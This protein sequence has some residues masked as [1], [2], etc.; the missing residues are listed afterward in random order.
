MARVMCVDDN[1]PVRDALRRMLELSGHACVAELESADGLGEAFGRSTPDVVL[2]DIDMPGRDSL[3]ALAELVRERPEARVVVLS[4]H[5]RRDLVERALDAG[6]W[7]Y[8]SKTE[9]PERIG[10]AVARVVSG[11]I[12]M[13]RDVEE[14][15]RL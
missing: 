8:V 2:L 9:S 10:E 3:E 13:G 14:M 11:E 5:V 4:G 12:A 1:R 7:G 15:L 6:A